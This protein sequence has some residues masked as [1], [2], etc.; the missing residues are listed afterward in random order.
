MKQLYF[1]I[2]IVF[3][4]SYGYAQTDSLIFQNGNYITGE[5]KSMKKGVLKVETAYSNSD[6]EVEWKNTKFIFSNQNFN[7]QLVNGDRLSGT[8][9]IDSNSTNINLTTE[10]GELVSI[11]LKDV[12][13]I[14][15]Y[16]SS[17]TDRLSASIDFGYSITKANTLQQYS[18]RSSISYITR[19]WKVYGS[20]NSI[21]SSQENSPDTKRSD[22]NFGVDYFLGNNYFARAENDFLSNDEQDIRLRSVTS[23]GLG[24]FI[25]RTNQLYWGFILGTAYNS[26]DFTTDGSRAQ[27][28]AEG[29]ISMEFNAFDTGDLSFSTSI[30]AYPSFT[31]KGRI[32]TDVK[33]DFKYDLP[34]DF[35]IGFGGTYNF[36]NQP[37]DG[38][39]DSDYVL[40]STIGWSL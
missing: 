14:T 8:I 30:A 32:R 6:F 2:L 28:S 9:S 23:I 40:Q 1:S 18:L 39:S 13:E 35:Y 37:V 4:F 29:L 20:A 11:L 17:F 34:L 24:K 38:A 12:T 27:S 3:M 5:I 15:T 21:R 10:E 26:E 19:K 16:N 25:V 33:A 36:D 7:F 22:G 31:E